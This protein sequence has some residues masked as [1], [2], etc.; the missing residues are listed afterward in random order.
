MLAIVN[1]DP[2][3]SELIVPFLSGIGIPNRIL[4]NETEI[5]TAKGIILPNCGDLKDAIR[6]LHLKNLFSALRICRK[7]VL[8]IGNGMI[9]MCEKTYPDNLNGF[10]FFDLIAHK[11]VNKNINEYV[12]ISRKYDCKIF[13]ITEESK[14]QLAEV[15]YIVKD[16]TYTSHLMEL[17]NE[18]IAACLEKSNYFG[19]ALNP[20]NSFE[21]GILLLKN[22]Y[23]YCNT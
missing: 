11:L 13:D 20:I 17:N 16:N 23:D 1:Y 9:M 2:I 6:Q 14:V 22:F 5:L 8:G 19:T 10:G 18:N 21:A 3:Q 4:L 7:P 15:D 12:I